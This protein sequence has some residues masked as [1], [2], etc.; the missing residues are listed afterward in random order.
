[1]TKYQDVKEIYRVADKYYKDNNY[2]TVVA[3]AIAAGIGFGKAFH[4]YRKLGRRRGYG[5]Q[6]HTQAAA[7]EK[8]GLKLP[9]L[10]EKS[11]LS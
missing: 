4:T 3:L 2:C 10:L 8:F 7:L 9:R 1:M 5:T 11:P 6:R